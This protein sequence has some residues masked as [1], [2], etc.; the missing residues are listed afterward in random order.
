M[1]GGR[2]PCIQALWG[3]VWM[4]ADN[5]STSTRQSDNVLG[6]LLVAKALPKAIRPESLRFITLFIGNTTYVLSLP[7]C[8]SPGPGLVVFFFTR[9]NIFKPLLT[10]I[11]KLPWCIHLRPMLRTN[12]G[13]SC[14][15]DITLEAL[16]RVW[17]KRAS[18]QLP[19]VEVDACAIASLC[20]GNL[21]MM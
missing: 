8:N 1:T 5:R 6:G 10:N 19:T 17:Y 3:G 14:L 4:T 11:T 16:R 20:A 13:A 2:R 18:V 21:L 15:P 7:N 9:R 12:S